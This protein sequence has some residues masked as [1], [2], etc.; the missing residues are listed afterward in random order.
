MAAR[1][2]KGHRGEAE[3]AFKA[4]VLLPPDRLM[5]RQTACSFRLVFLRHEDVLGTASRS[6]ATKLVD[7]LRWV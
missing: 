6:A 4:R 1:E 5:T 3:K 2:D 7:T